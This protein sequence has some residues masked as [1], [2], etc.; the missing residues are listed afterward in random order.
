[1]LKAELASIKPSRAQVCTAVFTTINAI[2][3]IILVLGLLTGGIVLRMA[4]V[5][6]VNNTD[7]AVVKSVNQI[8]QDTSFFLHEARLSYEA[9]NGVLPI[10][11]NAL[12]TSVNRALVATSTVLGS[13]NCDAIHTATTTLG[14][15]AVQQSVATYANQIMENILHTRDY[16]DVLSSLLKRTSIKD[17]LTSPPSPSPPASG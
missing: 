10:D 16:L 7:P 17:L 3:N 5:K 14:E 12:L 9:N 11:L 2:M 4:Y 8:V 1:M 13:V 6:V 15:P